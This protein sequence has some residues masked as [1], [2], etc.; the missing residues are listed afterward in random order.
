[1]DLAAVDGADPV[2]WAAERDPVRAEVPACPAPV[3]ADTPDASVADDCGDD[4]DDAEEGEEDEVPL[5]PAAVL[6]VAAPDEDTP[7]EVCDVLDDPAA[8]GAAPFDVVGPFDDAPLPVPADPPES[9]A[10]VVEDELE[11]EWVVSAWAAPAPASTAAP[12][13]TP[14]APAVNQPDTGNTRPT[15]PSLRRVS[16]RCLAAIRRFPSPVI[17]SLISE[18]CPAPCPTTSAHRTHQDSL[19]L[20]RGIRARRSLQPI[21]VTQ[22]C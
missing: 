17:R 22:I 16:L 5:P 19:P 4:T 7:L 10:C 20:L 8:D 18:P 15:P 11:S 6:T 2:V 1:M 21:D 13:P 14:T 3:E 9:P 12:T